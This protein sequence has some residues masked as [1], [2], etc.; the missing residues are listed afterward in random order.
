MLV[1]CL[2]FLLKPP[3]RYMLDIC[4]KNCR[5]GDATVGACSAAEKSALTATAAKV[6]TAQKAFTA[7]AEGRNSLYK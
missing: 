7:V 4:T 3:I 1:I 5:L 6:E 2:F